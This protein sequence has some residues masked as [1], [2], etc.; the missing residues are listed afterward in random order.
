M[1]RAL[2]VISEAWNPEWA[3]V[4]SLDAMNSRNFSAKRPF[5]DWMIYVPAR[6]SEVPAP[7]SVKQLPGLGSIVVVQPTPPSA[8][9]QQEL[10]RIRLI[11][12][13]VQKVS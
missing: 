1:A 11:D 9:D 13:L 5:V 4:M 6:I 2:S 3:G 8:E 10:A 7:S 12:E